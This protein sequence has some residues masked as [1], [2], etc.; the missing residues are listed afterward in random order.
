MIH[1]VTFRAFVASTE[2]AWRVREALTL[3]VPPELIS[4]TEAVGH[5][6]NKLEI[7]DAT[8]DKKEGMKF[9]R[10]LRE[11]LPQGEMDRL[12]QETPRRVDEDCQ[13]HF[14]LDKQAAYKGEAHLTDS[15]DSIQ[16]CTRLESYPARWEKAVKV[17]EDLL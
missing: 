16:V 14:R 4:S 12:R 15:G 13:L 11:I 17:A 10:K 8:L 5:Y 1:R 9:F 6:G 3:Y 7:L 2:E